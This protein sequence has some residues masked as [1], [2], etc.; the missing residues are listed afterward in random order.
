[1]L[2]RVRQEHRLREWLLQP[3]PV[4]ERLCL[5]GRSVRRRLV[6]VWI[7]RRPEQEQQRV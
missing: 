3:R 2:G 1:M 5:H 7:V 4:R 6:S